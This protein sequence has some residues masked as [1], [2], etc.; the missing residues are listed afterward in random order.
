[1]RDDPGGHAVDLLAIRGSPD[2]GPEKP[3]ASL[4]QSVVQVRKNHIV[5][6]FHRVRVERN[7]TLQLSVRVQE[8]GKAR[9][10]GRI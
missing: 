9:L 4:N 6:V 1:M 2:F 3:Q 7:W 10:P 5:A 8:A